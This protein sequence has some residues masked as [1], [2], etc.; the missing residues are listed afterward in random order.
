MSLEDK[1]NVESGDD[2]DSFYEKMTGF[3]IS[4]NAPENVSEDALKANQS[5]KQ[6]AN[7]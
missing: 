7:S 2:Y 6:P 3:K 4:K 5:I 1:K